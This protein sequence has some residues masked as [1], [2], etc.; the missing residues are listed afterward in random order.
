M[1]E[2]GSEFSQIILK[3]RD[4]I[5]YLNNN[6]KNLLTFSGRTSIDVVLKNLE[7]ANKALLPSYCCDSIIDPFRKAGIEVCFYDVN[8]DEEADINININIPDDVDVFLWCNY[9][10]Y[11]LQ[12]PNITDFKKR[13]GIVIE[14]ITHS[15]LSDTTYDTQSDFLVA[16][17]RKWLPVLCG[18]YCASVN[19]SLTE[20]PKVYPA[21]AF[22]NKKGMR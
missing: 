10:G 9:F 18:G 12:M 19:S 2:I 21:E 15:L 6:R 1:R 4:D 16:S 20:M 14:D 3:N 7:S 11:R 13:G 22:L 17:I 8:Y 5:V